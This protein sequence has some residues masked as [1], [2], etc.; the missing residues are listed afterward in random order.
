MARVI[1]ER[2][3]WKLRKSFA[4]RSEG[5]ALWSAIYGLLPGTRVNG[6]C[7]F[8]SLLSIFFF[9]LSFFLLRFGFG[10][11]G[12]GGVAEGCGFIRCDV[13]F[14]LRFLCYV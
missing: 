11:R 10:G 5:R 3:R 13:W 6:C 4:F 8:A 7:G 12:G 9:L 2:L 14:R 1:F